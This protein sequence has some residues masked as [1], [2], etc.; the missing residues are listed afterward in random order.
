MDITQQAL[1]GAALQGM[2]ACT[3]VAKIPAELAARLDEQPHVIVEDELGRQRRLFILLDELNEGDRI[4]PR[5]ADASRIY[6][7]ARPTESDRAKLHRRPNSLPDTD[8][9]NVR[10]N[11]INWHIIPARQ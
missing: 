8:A 4:E 5:W 11:P 1:L 10:P 9:I 3:V 6:E 7:H 2:R